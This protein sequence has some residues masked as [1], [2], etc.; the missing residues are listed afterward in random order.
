MLTKSKAK[1]HATERRE[2]DL[3]ATRRSFFEQPARPRQAAGYVVAIAG[4]AALTAAFRP[5][6]ASVTPLSEG[7]AYLT[8]VVAVAWIGGLGPGIL[9]SVLAFVTFNFFFLPP[10]DT[11]IIERPEYIVV[12]FVQLGISVL[13]S[14]L[15]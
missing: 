10:Y 1:V 4:I 6:R 8:L 11:F 15:L 5:F 13:I 14:M 9:A 12:L 2:I 7:F 3:T